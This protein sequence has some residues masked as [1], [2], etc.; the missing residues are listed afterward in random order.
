MEGESNRPASQLNQLVHA[1][2][3]ADH[4]NDEQ[5]LIAIIQLL[6]SCKWDVDDLSLFLKLEH[7]YCIEPDDRN[8]VEDLLKEVM[9]GQPEITLS[10]SE[11]M[12]RVL[13]M[14]SSPQVSYDYN[15]MKSIVESLSLNNM[16]T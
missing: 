2:S 1:F 12:N 16:V 11:K 14:A 6:E 3:L 15:H 13:A 4:N 10:D 7:H 5:E 8:Q 9:V